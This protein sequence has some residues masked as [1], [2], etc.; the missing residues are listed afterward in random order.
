[1]KILSNKTE[2]LINGYLFAL[3]DIDGSYMNEFINGTFVIQSKIEDIE[4]FLHL[5]YK[6]LNNLKIIKSF[7]DETK[8]GYDNYFKRLLL[9]DPF[10]LFNKKTHLSKQAKMQ[11]QQRREYMILHL[12]DQI[13]T[14][15]DNYGIDMLFNGTVNFSIFSEDNVKTIFVLSIKKKDICMIFT[16]FRERI[17]IN[18]G[19]K[20]FEEIVDEH[21]AHTKDFRKSVKWRKEG[22][23][24][25][26]KIKQQGYIDK[27]SYE[28]LSKYFNP[29]IIKELK[30]SMKID[31]LV[32]CDAK[33]I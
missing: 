6:S 29:K 26:K 9:Q 30:M 25:L 15:F 11:I 18:D 14:V 7:R 5:K 22:E 32:D 31:K 24:L 28:M 1:M 13:D 21:K 17:S 20:L 33:K 10:G 8:Y 2:T 12:T 4:K 19:I 23:A 3:S 27:K 16:F